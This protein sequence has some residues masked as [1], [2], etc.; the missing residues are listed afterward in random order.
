[1]RC[2]LLASAVHQFIL[3]KRCGLLGDHPPPESLQL[4]RDVE[5]MFKLLAKFLFAPPLYKLYP[6][7]NWKRLLRTQEGIV[8]ELTK[9]G[10]KE[11][12]MQWSHAL[13]HV[14]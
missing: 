9:V 1:M 6:T 10:E 11:F 5:M 4:I 3:S 13:N 12:N 14:P 2:H 7:K 8:R